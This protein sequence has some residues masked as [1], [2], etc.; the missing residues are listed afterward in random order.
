MAESVAQISRERKTVVLVGN[1][2][3]I[4][5]FGI[6]ERVYRRTQS[7]YRTIYL[8]GVDRPAERSYAD[9][10]WM[11]PPRKNPSKGKTPG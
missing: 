7:T 10:L 4:Y 6:P 11:T 1:G 9:Y 5:K 2:H 3:I 8:V